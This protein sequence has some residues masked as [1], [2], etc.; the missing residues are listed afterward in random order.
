LSLIEDIFERTAQ[1]S[2]KL[3]RYAD[4]YTLTSREVQTGEQFELRVNR[5]HVFEF[6]LSDLFSLENYQNML[7]LKLEELWQSTAN[8]LK[9]RIY[10]TK[11]KLI[12]HLFHLFEHYFSSLNLLNVCFHSSLLVKYYIFIVYELFSS[13]H[14]IGTPRFSQ[15]F[16][17]RYDSFSLLSYLEKD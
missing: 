16:V 13:H 10:I 12:M 6:K 4:K 9:A 14:I 7:S 3:V 1:E 15:L 11:R 5:K 17:P 2:V 8:K